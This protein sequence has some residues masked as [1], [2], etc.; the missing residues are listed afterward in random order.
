MAHFFKKNFLLQR[1]SHNG[2]VGRVVGFDTADLHFESRPCVIFTNALN[3]FPPTI[4]YLQI[5]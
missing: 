5:I 3:F 2:L 4:L 1:H